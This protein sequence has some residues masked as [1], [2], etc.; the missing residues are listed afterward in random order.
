MAQ[1]KGK[2]DRSAHYP[3]NLIIRFAYC[4]AHKDLDYRVAYLMGSI[5]GLALSFKKAG[6][7]LF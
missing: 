2:A 4:V 1:V 5:A 7:V 3:V 6:L